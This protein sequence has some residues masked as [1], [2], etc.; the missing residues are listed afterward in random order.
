MTNGGISEIKYTRPLV[1]VQDIVR[2]IDKGEEYSRNLPPTSNCEA[3]NIDFLGAIIL[4]PTYQREYRSTQKEESLIIESILLNI[5]IPEVFLVRIP[6][7]GYQVR[8]VMD[9]RHRLNAI[10]RFIKGV[11]KLQGLEII[12][13]NTSDTYNGKRFLELSANDKIKLLTYKIS[14]LEFD[15]LA[16]DELERELFT[17]YNKATKPLEDQEIR[18]ATY[19]SKTSLFVSSFINKLKSE[20]ETSLY[21]AYNVTKNRSETQRLHQNIFTIL[22]IIEE[23]LNTKLTKSTEVAEEYMKLK[24]TQYKNNEEKEGEIID[25]FNNFNSFIEKISTKIEYPFSSKLFTEKTGSG[26]YLFQIGIAMVLASLFYYCDIKID[27]EFNFIE[28][29]STCINDMRLDKTA[30]V[31]C[32]TNSRIIALNLKN[33]DFKKY[34]NLSKKDILDTLVVDA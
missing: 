16:D 13:K 29:I 7:N 9:G 11:Y 23:G 12:T 15:A 32:S 3:E 14:I 27:E 21:K 33:I 31:S 2:Y 8:N 5:P 26:S 30:Y 20:K 25:I 19:L 28:D 34:K 18:Y 6:G 4:N 10:Y 22:H 17:R 1:S 24:N